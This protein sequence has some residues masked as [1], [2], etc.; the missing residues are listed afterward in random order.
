MRKP[1]SKAVVRHESSRATELP[2][3]LLRHLGEDAL[4]YAK[5]AEAQGLSRQAKEND[6]I[7]NRYIFELVMRSHDEAEA[8]NAMN[9]WSDRY[10]KS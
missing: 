2:N 4:S 9:E 6:N 1:Y 5:Q 8:V 7:A 10:G 3:K